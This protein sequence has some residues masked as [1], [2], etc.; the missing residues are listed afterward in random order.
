MALISFDFIVDSALT[1]MDRV[2]DHWM[3]CIDLTPP[4]PSAVYFTNH[5]IAPFTRIPMEAAQYIKSF[6]GHCFAVGRSKK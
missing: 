4:V 6:Q 2:H 3:T 5:S 1:E